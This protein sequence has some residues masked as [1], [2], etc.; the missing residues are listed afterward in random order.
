MHSF[1]LKIT[2][3]ATNPRVVATVLSQ[4]AEDLSERSTIPVKGEL[5]HPETGHH[6][7]S[8]EVVDVRFGL[9]SNT[10][11]PESVPNVDDDS[12]EEFPNEFTNYFVH[13]RTTW[14]DQWSSTCNDDCP[15]CG[16]EIE[17]YAS[18]D[19]EGDVTLHVGPDFVPED[20]W[21]QGCT[22]A[23]DLPGWPVKQEEAPK[24]E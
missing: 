12:E 1:T 8:Y 6:L 7:G 23:D 20:G 2:D 10:Q 9:L 3:D 21:P 19:G 11:L 5:L 14:T 15:Q 17:P 4:L 18:E 24:I 16:Q 13:C 22:T